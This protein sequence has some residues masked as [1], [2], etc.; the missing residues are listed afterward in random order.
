MDNKEESL[1][2]VLIDTTARYNPYVSRSELDPHSKFLDEPRLNFDPIGE[3]STFDSL[4]KID[5]PGIGTQELTVNID[6][7]KLYSLGRPL[8]GV[9]ATR[10]TPHHAVRHATEKL[11]GAG[12]L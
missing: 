3:L 12:S 2:S 6:V 7:R 8:W 4:S 5:G 10:Y 9:Y 1:F 11:Y